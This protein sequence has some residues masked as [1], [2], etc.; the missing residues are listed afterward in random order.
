[1]IKEEPKYNLKNHK[2]KPSSYLEE[3]CSHLLDIEKRIHKNAVNSSYWIL[4][5]KNPVKSEKSFHVEKVTPELDGVD[6][7]KRIIK[8]ILSNSNNKISISALGLRFSKKVQS[9]GFDNK[10]E[11]FK[12]VGIRPNITISTAINEYMSEEVTLEDGHASLNRR[13]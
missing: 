6:K 10:K 4:E 3:Y 12:Q 1:M 7:L 9:M 13:D 5:K 11:F 8:E 2:I